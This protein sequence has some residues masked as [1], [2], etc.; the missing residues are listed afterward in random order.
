MAVNQVVVDG[1]TIIDLTADTVTVDNLLV[2]ATAHDAAGNQIAG[3]ATGGSSLEIANAVILS[4]DQAAYILHQYSEISYVSGQRAVYSNVGSSIIAQGYSHYNNVTALVQNGATLAD[5]YPDGVPSSYLS[6]SLDMATTDGLIITHYLYDVYLNQYSGTTYQYKLR[7]S[8]D[9]G[10]TWTVVSSSFTSNTPELGT[11]WR[12]NDIYAPTADF[13]YGY[14]TATLHYYAYISTY[15]GY[16][17][18]VISINNITRNVKIPFASEA[19]Y[20]AAVALT[21]EPNTLTEI[22]ET[23]TPSN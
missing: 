22:E 9:G 16:R 18:I 6:Y 2:G 5:L 10:S 15:Q 20:N 13:V 17:D 4:E 23:L 12:F 1:E 11:Y 14:A 21:Y 8:T 7:Y 3:Q 19:E